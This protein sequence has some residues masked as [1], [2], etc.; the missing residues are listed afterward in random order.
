[1]PLSLAGQ[2]NYRQT[3]QITDSDNALPVDL[4]YAKVYMHVDHSDDDALIT[5]LIYAAAKEIE[6]YC[7]HSLMTKTHKLFLSRW[8]YKEIWL[9][10]GPVQ[11]VSSISY[12]DSSNTLVVWDA[13]NYIV[14][15]DCDP[16]IITFDIGPPT[17]YDRPDAIVV[18]YEA[19]YGLTSDDVPRWAKAQI[20]R[21]VLFWYDTPSM[22]DRRWPQDVYQQL[23]KYRRFYH[24]AR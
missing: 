16:A 12:Y 14:S 20:M 7:W 2:Q 8:P 1:M 19:G 9:R 24:D 6:E 23:Y 21:L 22:T 13:S 18:E 5:D 3:L 10:R 15:K 4:E 11:S 17:S